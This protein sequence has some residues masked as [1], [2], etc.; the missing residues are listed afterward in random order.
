VDGRGFAAVA[1]DHPTNVGQADA[2][3]FEFI[4]SVQTLNNSEELVG[5]IAINGETP[6][7]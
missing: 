4:A 5:A 6:S 1:A 7:S 2:G 3:A